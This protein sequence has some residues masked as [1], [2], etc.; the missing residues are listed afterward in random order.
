MIRAMWQEGILLRDLGDLMKMWVALG[1]FS[2][3]S[4]GVDLSIK[5]RATNDTS[6]FSQNIL[7]E[8]RLKPYT[9]QAV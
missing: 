7:E 5:C 4:E 8:P 9:L 2:Q 3:E 6:D 1:R